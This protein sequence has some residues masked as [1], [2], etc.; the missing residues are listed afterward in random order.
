MCNRSLSAAL[1]I[2][3]FLEVFG[4]WGLA[5]E[6]LEANFHIVIVM[7]DVDYDYLLRTFLKSWY[8]VAHGLIL[9]MPFLSALIIISIVGNYRQKTVAHFR[10]LRRW[11]RCEKANDRIDYNIETMQSII[12]EQM[13]QRQLNNFPSNNEIY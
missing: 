4:K 1:L 9:L 12:A 3:A 6:L 10:Q 2:I 5:V 7:D 13:R 8:K 11:I